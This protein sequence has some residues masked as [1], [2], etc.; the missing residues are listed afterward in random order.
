MNKASRKDALIYAVVLNWNNSEDTGECIGSLLK[1]VHPSLRVVVV[2]NGSTDGS[3]RRLKEAFPDVMVLQTGRNLGY[4]GGNNMG[5]RHALAHGAKWVLILN[6]DTV[7][8][9]HLLERL[10]EAAEEKP[11]GGIYGPKVLFYHEPERVQYAGT[12]RVRLNRFEHVGSGKLDRNLQDP[13][14]VETDWA[15][16]CAMLVSSDVFR[17]AGLLDARYF[18]FMEEQEFSYRARRKGFKTYFVPRARV[19]HKSGVTFTKAHGP[20]K[21]RRQIYFYTRNSLLWIESYL[22]PLEKVGAYVSYLRFAVG[23]LRRLLRYSRSSPEWLHSRAVLRAFRDY[24]FRRFGD[25]P[26]WL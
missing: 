5:I 8:D 21:D 14:T 13:G 26:R 9:G 6:N 10:M 11:E 24:I 25:A 16:G 22:P 1:V 18:L 2:D 12:R 7:V 4:A 15:A 17:G 3:G 23:H 19:W 20:L